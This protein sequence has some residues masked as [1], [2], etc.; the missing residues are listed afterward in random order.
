MLEPVV[1]GAWFEGN[2]IKIDGTFRGEGESQS[3]FM[4]NDGTEEDG[5]LLFNFLDKKQ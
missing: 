5:R 4:Y 3:A 2:E 1:G